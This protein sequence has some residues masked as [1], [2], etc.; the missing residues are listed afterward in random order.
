MGKTLYHLDN[1]LFRVKRVLL[2][3]SRSIPVC[4]HLSVAIEAPLEL[5]G[6]RFVE[7]WVGA[8]TN[9]SAQLSE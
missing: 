3:G 7:H 2:H 9:R 5:A 8:A 6:S 4:L 1:N